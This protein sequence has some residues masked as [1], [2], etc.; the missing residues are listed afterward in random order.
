MIPPAS[1]PIRAAIRILGL[2]LRASIPTARQIRP[3]MMATMIAVG[4]PVRNMGGF[5][6]WRSMFS[7]SDSGAIDGLLFR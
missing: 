7:F 5:Q 6:I 4:I 3:V 1:R 2:A